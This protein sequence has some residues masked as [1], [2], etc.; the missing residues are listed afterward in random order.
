MTSFEE[1]RTR[2]LERHGE[3]LA[4]R[5]PHPKSAAEIA[6]LG[7]DRFLSA[8]GKGI[9]A[10]GFRWQVVQAKWPETEQA[11]HGFDP[12]WVAS[13][14]D[15]QFSALKADRRIIRNGPKIRAIVENAS[16]IQDV[17]AEHGSFARWI[18]EWPE[19]DVVGLWWT[20]KDGGSR[21]GGNTGPR[22]LRHMGKDTFILTDDVAGGLADL[23]LMKGK[24]T[25]KGAMRQAQEAFNAWKAETGLPL[26][27]LSTILA[28]SRGKAYDRY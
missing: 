9:M 28:C 26:C 14:D 8:M 3:G 2:A 16:W 19:D 13:I 7:D 24:P 4:D 25:G 10:A 21:L 27:Q 5:L 18:A 20:L 1:V 6:A 22:F 23:G 12:G 15:E 17:A 11:F